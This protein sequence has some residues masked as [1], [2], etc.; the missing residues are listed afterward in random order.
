MGKYAGMEVIEVPGATG[1]Y[2]TNYLG[3]AEHALKALD[4][5]D[6]VYLHV[7]SIDEASHAGDLK[8]KIKTIE[9][10]DEKVLGT[11]LLSEQEFTIAV[12]PDHFTPI[13]TKTH[14]SEPVPFAVWSPQKEGDGIEKFDETSAKEGSAGNLYCEE[15]MRFL[16][17]N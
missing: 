6:Y 3:K 9:E 14:A 1:Y 2:D 10:F 12:L 8:M 16:L 4:T 5:S 17:E 11:L 13:S 7:E 15:F